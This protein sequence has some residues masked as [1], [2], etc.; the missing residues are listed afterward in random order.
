MAQQ[1]HFWQDFVNKTEQMSYADGLACAADLKKDYEKAIS[2]MDKDIT[3]WYKRFAD[4]AGI[5]LQAAKKVLNS[6]ELKEAH[7]TFSEYRKLAT[8]GNKDLELFLRAMSAKHRITRLEL[9]EAQCR[10]HIEDLKAAEV[11]KVGK[12]CKDVYKETY[13]RYIY[14]Q[15]VSAGFA[16]NFAKVNEKRL[17]KIINTPWGVQSRNYRTDIVKSNDRLFMEVNRELIQGCLTGAP[18]KELAEAVAKRMRVGYTSAYRR[19]RTESNHYANVAARD[20]YKELGARKYQVSITYDD[21]TCDACAGFDG[22]VLDMDMWE[23]GVTAPPFHINCR[24]MTI[25]Y[26]E[27]IIDPYETRA[28]RDSNGKT[29]YIPNTMTYQEWKNKYAN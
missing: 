7:M 12:M 17:E 9:L 20:S 23:E 18:L 11:G 22:Q 24:C 3:Y 5:S 4:E 14:G 28:A 26:N 29:I 27:G 10:F 25:P 16:L 13:N 15:S 21:R 2:S 1:L 8:E 19:V 6:D